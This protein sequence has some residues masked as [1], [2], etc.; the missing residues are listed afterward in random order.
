M[1]LTNQTDILLESGTNELEIV[2]FEVGG[3]T[4]GINV[5]KVR[6]IIQPVAVTETP[7]RHEHL[8][9]VVRLREEVIPVVD[10]AKVLGYPPSEQPEH[11]KFIIS[12]LNQM[13]VAFHVHSVSRIH[14]IS[15]E[16]IEKPGELSQGYDA[17]T[18]GIVKMEEKMSLLLD[19][20]KI[21]MDIAPEAGVNMNQVSNISYKDRTEKQLMIVEDSTILRQMLEDVLEEAGYVNS[22]VFQDGKAAWD[23]LQGEPEDVEERKLPD[24]IITDLEMP[25]MDGHHLT[26]K[27]KDHHEL[28]SIPVVIFSSL[29]T[30]DLYHKGEQ[31]GAEAQISKPEIVHLVDEIDTLILN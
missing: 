1:A 12:E 21:V 22:F 8:E 29:I 23:Y 31:V 20:E 9:G 16:Q 13:K 3:G 26:Y 4:F 6:E 7:N 15:W 18:I 2:M 14:R 28:K 10:L 11:D 30:E 24:L 27:I 5:L 19:Y 17:N 25:K